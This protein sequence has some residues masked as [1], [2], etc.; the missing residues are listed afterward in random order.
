M[1]QPTRSRK[2]RRRSESPLLTLML[3]LVALM[4]AS[5]LLYRVFFAPHQEPLEAPATLE[6][7]PSP[8]EMLPMSQL[9]SECFGQ[10]NGMKTYISDSLTAAQG[11]DVSSHQGWIDWQTVK[12]SGIDYAMIRAGYR[13][14]TDG[15]T[16]QDEYFSYNIDAATSAGINVGLY[17]FSQATSEEEA[18]AEADRVLQLVDGYTLNYPIYFDWEPVE[19][20]TARTS[21]ISGSDL[22]RYALAFCQTIEAAGY[23]AGIYFNLSM[24]S[25]LY[26]LYALQE[27][28]FWLAEYQEIPSFPYAID[29]WQYSSTG[30]VP[31]IDTI[32]DLNLSF[33]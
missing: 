19:D 16:N 8:T 13:G 14:Y 7:S 10:E 2:K 28:D 11:I 3:F 12:D 23:E 27:Y 9:A 33:S 20:E 1:A 29:M 22:T 15:E 21:T 5:F 32:V 31:G 18:V 25:Y 26:D 4:A 6:P 30:T 24:A 17:F